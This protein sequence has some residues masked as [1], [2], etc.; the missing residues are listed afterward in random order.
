MTEHTLWLSVL[1][2]RV[3]HDAGEEGL[4]LSVTCE[5]PNIPTKNRVYAMKVLTDYFHTQTQTQVYTWVL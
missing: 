1:Q 4:V 2:L 5:K 3:I